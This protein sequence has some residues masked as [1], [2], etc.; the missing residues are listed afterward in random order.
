M[1]EA[2]HFETPE[3]IKIAYKPAGL[4]TRFQAWAIDCILVWVV[5]FLG[6]FGMII[7]LAVLA[8]SNESIREAANSVEEIL[9]GD[10]LT[11]E[12]IGM[13]FLGLFY[14]FFG[15]G[16]FF[17]FGL[18][19]L[20][21]RGQTFGKRSAK[22]RV[23]K[24]DGFSLDASSIFLRNLFRLADQLPPLWAVPL[25]SSRSQR[26]GDMVSGTLVVADGEAEM[27]RLQA[28][29]SERT[30]ADAQFRFDAGALSKLRPQDTLAVETFL[31]RWGGLTGQQR[32]GMAQQIIPPIVDRLGVESPS[33][34]TAQ[35]A[36]QFLEDLLAAEYRRRSRALS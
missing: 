24:S 31:E 15:L 27:P 18:S 29:L 25:F 17:Y 30:A 23:V 22:I 5:A 26:F 10:G 16:S 6:F 9:E 36:R 11:P 14:L 21:L 3:N 33:I 12:Q 1:A 35:Q 4:G 32:Q 13:Y 8:D 7:L 20:F 19:E 2:V 28:A 34:E